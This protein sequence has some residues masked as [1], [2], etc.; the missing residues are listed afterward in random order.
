MTLIIK[1]MYSPRAVQNLT[2]GDKNDV[3]AFFRS[4]EINVPGSVITSQRNVITAS[5]YHYNSSCG[6]DRGKLGPSIRL[7]NQPGEIYSPLV[8]DG[9]IGRSFFPKICHRPFFVGE[10]MF[11]TGGL[12]PERSG[13]S[14][15]QYSWVSKR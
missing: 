11:C 6:G 13:S 10:R 3:C 14:T 4:D 1:V 12:M 8:K 15:C 5:A 2:R 9:Q 7:S